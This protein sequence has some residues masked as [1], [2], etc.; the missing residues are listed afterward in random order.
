MPA[1]PSSP[2]SGR[3]VCPGHKKTP[4][5]PGGLRDEGYSSRYGIM[6]EAC[7]TAVLT[8]VTGSRVPVP[9]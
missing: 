4:R 8:Y 2:V 7:R 9:R 3:G 1:V 6:S 5:V